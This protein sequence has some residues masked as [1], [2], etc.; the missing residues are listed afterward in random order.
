M[1]RNLQRQTW[2]I[3]VGRMVE[4]KGIAVRFRALVVRE[5]C[6]VPGP[7]RQF[8]VKH[9]PRQRHLARAD[10]RS[11]LGGYRPPECTGFLGHAPKVRSLLG[12]HGPPAGAP[13][14]CPSRGRTCGSSGITSSTPQPHAPSV[15][16][17]NRPT[18]GH[19]NRRP[20]TWLSWYAS[21]TPTPGSRAQDP[22]PR[23]SGPAFHCTHEAS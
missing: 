11:V 7:L 1:R 10:I 18:P 2:G 5:L 16:T 23:T 21:R 4:F 9:S 8:H 6:P 3:R 13:V 17:A 12:G 22:L 20:S 15:A 19:P 14:L